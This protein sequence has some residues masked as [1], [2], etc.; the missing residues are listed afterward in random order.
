MN[1][2]NTSLA[3]VRNAIGMFLGRASETVKKSESSNK[4]CFELHV[5]DFQPR[6]AEGHHL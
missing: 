2:V 6:D 4:E 1:V 5:Y 3:E